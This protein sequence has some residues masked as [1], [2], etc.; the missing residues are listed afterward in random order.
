MCTEELGMDHLVSLVNHSNAV[1][2]TAE[3]GKGHSVSAEPLK[4][5]Y[6]YY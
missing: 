4:E 1:K 6:E 2:G 5:R 3:L